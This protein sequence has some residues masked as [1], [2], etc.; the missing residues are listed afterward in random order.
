M[1]EYVNW[2]LIGYGK[3]GKKIEDSFLQT[4]YSKLLGIASKSFKSKIE[5]N[6][7]LQKDKTKIQKR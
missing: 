4:K 5:E 3:F 7:K 6:S 1:N 2:G